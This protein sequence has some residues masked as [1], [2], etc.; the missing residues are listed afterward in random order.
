MSTTLIRARVHCLTI[1]VFLLD[2]YFSLVLDLGHSASKRRPEM[3]CNFASQ[4]CCGAPNFTT[5]AHALHLFFVKSSTSFHILK[6]HRA[7]TITV[8]PQPQHHPVFV[9]STAQHLPT[10]HRRRFITYMRHQFKNLWRSP[11]YH[12]ITTTSLFPQHFLFVTFCT[13]VLII[14]S[15]SVVKLMWTPSLWISFSEMVVVLWARKK[16]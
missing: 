6:I 8:P 13:M 11:S 9:G 16:Y 4:N 3:S 10:H 7:S 5:H 2:S 12:N 14:L 15:L 1:L